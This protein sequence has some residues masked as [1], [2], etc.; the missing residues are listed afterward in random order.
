MVRRDDAASVRLRRQTVLC[1]RHCSPSNAPVCADRDDYG[2]KIFKSIEIT[3]V[4]TT[5]FCQNVARLTFCL[6]IVVRRSATSACA[7]NIQSA[8]GTSWRPCRAGS[9]RKRCTPL[10][11]TRPIRFSRSCLCS[12][13]SRAQAARR[14]A[15]YT[16]S[17]VSMLATP[18]MRRRVVWC[19]TRPCCFARCAA[20]AHTKP[21]ARI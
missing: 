12:G 14:G 17:S 6:W 5:I 13:R 21:T 15:H 18:N 2:N 20:H 11:H 1:D 9:R 3:L 8:A 16:H 4:S 7:P 10:P 19:R